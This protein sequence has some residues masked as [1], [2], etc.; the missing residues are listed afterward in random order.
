MH[1]PAGMAHAFAELGPH[2]KLWHLTSLT[3]LQVQRVA[4]NFHV[5]VS[6]EDFF[7]LEETQ[8]RTY[9]MTCATC[10]CPR[11]S[12]RQRVSDVPPAETMADADAA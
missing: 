5:T 8:A 2:S 7:M 1:R 11:K 3:W 12:L 4:G 9:V 10:T 6:M